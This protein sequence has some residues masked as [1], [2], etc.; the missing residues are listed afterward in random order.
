M[1]VEFFP[2]ISM[3]FNPSPSVGDPASQW[4]HSIRVFDS[5]NYV[6]IFF[7]DGYIIGCQLKSIEAGENK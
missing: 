7:R 3:Y 1:T 4:D 2:R 5:F 6:D